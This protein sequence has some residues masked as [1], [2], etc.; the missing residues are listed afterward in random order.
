MPDEVDHRRA[1]FGGPLLLGDMA[2]ALQNDQAAEL[3]RFSV[4]SISRSRQP[5]S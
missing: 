2:A 1:D 4:N 3:R 5:A